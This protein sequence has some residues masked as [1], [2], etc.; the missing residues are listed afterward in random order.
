MSRLVRL[1]SALAIVL[2][3]CAGSADAGEA[4]VPLTGFHPAGIDLSTAQLAPSDVRLHLEIFFSLRNR[5]E[6]EERA[7]K[8]QDPSSPEYHHWLTQPE[9]HARFGESADEYQAVRAWLLSQG[10]IITEESYGGLPDWIRFTATVAQAEKTF[11]VAIVATSGGNY[12]NTS[13]PLI[14]ARF[15]AVIS[16][17]LGL[18]NISALGP[19]PKQGVPNPHPP[20]SGFLPSPRVSVQNANRD[21]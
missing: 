3:A 9:S 5:Q 17:I 20:H 6:M 15:A 19:G 14:P 13:D 2:V 11:G 7:K 1:L 21:A 16:S 8:V 4:M 10:F 12:A 18:D